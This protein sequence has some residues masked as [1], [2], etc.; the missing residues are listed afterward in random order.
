MIDEV[1][2]TFIYTL[3]GLGKLFHRCDRDTEYYILYMSPY[4]R[5]NDNQTM[6]TSVIQIGELI[7]K[8]S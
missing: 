6:V 3:K 1:P 4:V 7:D 8:H 5:A 2:Y